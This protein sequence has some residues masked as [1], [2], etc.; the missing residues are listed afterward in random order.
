MAKTIISVGIRTQPQAQETH[1]KHLSQTTIPKE[2]FLMDQTFVFIY[3][4]RLSL[5]ILSKQRSSD[6]YNY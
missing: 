2:D 3:M 6:I 5:N 1:P 4:N